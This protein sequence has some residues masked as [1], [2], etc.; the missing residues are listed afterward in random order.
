MAEKYLDEPSYIPPIPYEIVDAIQN[1][2]LVVFIGAGASYLVGCTLWKDLADELLKVCK[3]A[4]CIDYRD[5]ISFRRVSDCRKKITVSYEKLVKNDKEDMFWEVMAKTL[6]YD[7]EQVGRQNVYKLIMALQPKFYV[8]TNADE[9]LDQM[10]YRSHIIWRKED[11]TDQKIEKNKLFHIHGSVKELREVI[12][13]LPDYLARYQSEEFISFLKKVFH[14]HTVLFIGYGLNELELMEYMNLKTGSKLNAVMLSMYNF[15]D[16]DQIPLDADY[17]G[18]MG[19]KMLPYFAD[20]GEYKYQLE[21]VLAEWGDTINRRTG[22]YPQRIAEIEQIIQQERVDQFD[23]MDGAA[24]Y[25]RDLRTEMMKLIAKCK[26]P[27]IW[28]GKLHDRDY[29]DPEKGLLVYSDSKGLSPLFWSIL[30]V[31]YAAAVKWSDDASLSECRGLIRSSLDNI[32]DYLEINK[33]D[34]TDQRIS[35]NLI[36]II[37]YLPIK[38]QD[39][40]YVKKS[41]D[42]QNRLVDFAIES[43]L[44]PMLVH[45]Q[46][47]DKLLNLTTYLLYFKK[48]GNKIDPRMDIYHLEKIVSRWLPRLFDILQTDFLDSVI[49]IID[50]LESED[51]GEFNYVAIPTIEKDSASRLHEYPQMLVGAVRDLLQ[52]CGPKHAAEYTAAFLTCDKSIFQR[53]AYHVINQYYEKLQGL[54][55]DRKNPLAEF[56]NKH[57]VFELLRTHANDFTDEQ[58][59]RLREWIEAIDVSER[60]EDM[61]P[62]EIQRANAYRRKEWL[63]AVKEVD[64]FRE[65]YKQYDSV[66]PEKI[67]HPGMLFWSEWGAREKCPIE[68]NKL[69]AMDAEAI[70]GAMIEYRQEGQTFISKREALDDDVSEVLRENPKKL[71][72]MVR[73]M[74]RIPE[75]YLQHLVQDST[76]VRSKLSKEEQG[77]I[78]ASLRIMLDKQFADQS[79]FECAVYN[80]LWFVESGLAGEKRFDHELDSRL[81]DLIQRIKELHFTE[82]R[83]VLEDIQKHHYVQSFESAFLKCVFQLAL[84]ISQTHQ[85]DLGIKWDPELQV[86]IEEHFLPAGTGSLIAHHILGDQFAV[87]MYLNPKWAERHIADMFIDTDADRW[88]AAT[89]GMIYGIHRISQEVFKILKIHGVYQR[90]LAADVEDNQFYTYLAQDIC[91]GYLWGWDEIEEENSVSRLLIHTQKTEITSAT[92]HFLGHK[93]EYAPE[94]LE[95]VIQLWKAMYA[96]YRTED[97]ETV[98]VT[99]SELPHIVALIDYIDDET[100]D[101]LMYSARYMTEDRLDTISFIEGLGGHVQRSPQ[102]VGEILAE[103]IQH[104]TIPLYRDDEIRNIVE[105]VYSGGFTEI[106]NSIC[107]AYLKRGLRILVDIYDRYNPKRS[108]GHRE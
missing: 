55:W 26:S 21:K 66:F 74:D 35:W 75:D 64:T 15:S 69:L 67:R 4:G 10:L 27:C 63:E 58:N 9:F 93:T 101:N 49:D 50:Q 45:N 2:K 1:E 16:R 7:E 48:R 20:Q 11:I 38:D 91:I 94:I 88:M 103:M 60:A 52:L 68:R 71:I 19:I 23:A 77:E 102:A 76:Q 82:E 97:P 53:I 47:R 42:K 24:R 72:E 81:K 6:R 86:I 56:Q 70:V 31:L 5:Y 59:V 17:Y 61:E 79:S 106:A 37:A 57:E 22:Y 39:I 18:T 105:G 3:D 25:D 95:R 89:I 43:D 80:L 54:F 40:K 41:L 32:I 107:I 8:T 12:F 100:A 83:A 92:I 108:W 34:D 51:P 84:H 33:D 29:F 78:L 44:F 96:R 14:E 85:S 73:I 90:A 13:K 28:I 30:D 62:Y 36:R 65:L 104:G 46:D 99:L 87:I 98:R